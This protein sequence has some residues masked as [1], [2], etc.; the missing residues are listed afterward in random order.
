MGFLLFTTL[1][2]STASL[3]LL[4]SIVISSSQLS[5]WQALVLFQQ[6]TCW[7]E[8]R[9]EKRGTFCDSFQ[10]GECRYVLRP[11]YDY[12]PPDQPLIGSLVGLPWPPAWGAS[13]LGASFLGGC[14]GFLVIG[15]CVG[16]FV[17]LDLLDEDFDLLLGDGVFP[18]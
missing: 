18:F 14:V 7:C 4:L 15:G 16:F 8:A 9:E 6:S 12:H 5:P 2:Y 1:L 17:L 3:M 10:K 13:V 11:F